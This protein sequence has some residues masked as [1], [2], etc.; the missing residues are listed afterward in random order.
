MTAK[1]TYFSESTIAVI[2]FDREEKLFCV[3]DLASGH[4]QYTHHWDHAKWLRDDIV[5]SRKRYDD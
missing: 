4:R 2:E 3:V 5:Q 1:K